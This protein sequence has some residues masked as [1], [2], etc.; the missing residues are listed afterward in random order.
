LDASAVAAIIPVLHAHNYPPNM[1]ILEDGSPGDAIYFIASGRVVRHSPNGTRAYNTGDVFGTFAMIL[2]DKH[3][4]AFLT[5]SK[6]RLLKL[7]RED[8]LRL[9][10]THPAVTRHIRRLAAQRGGEEAD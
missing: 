10:I 3:Q 8:F 1:K 6:C 4:A 9:E 2:G 7:H 5:G